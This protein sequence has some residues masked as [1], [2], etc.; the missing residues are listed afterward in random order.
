M[1]NLLENLPGLLKK[2][3]SQ[4]IKGKPGDWYNIAPLGK[5]LKE[6]GIEYIGKLKEVL[7]KVEGIEFYEDRTKTTPV[8]YVRLLNEICTIRE[9]KDERKSRPRNSARKALFEW[10]FWGKYGDTLA[11]L[12]EKSLGGESWSFENE[13]DGRFSILDSYLRYTFFRIQKEGKICYTKD[14]QWAIFNTGLVNKTYLPIYALFAKNKIQGKQSWFFNGFFAEGEKSKIGRIS[15]VDFP[16]RPRRAQYFDDPTDLLYIVSES[17][18]ELSP[19]YEHIITDNVERLPITLLREF[20]SET[21]EEKKQLKDFNNEEEYCSYCKEYKSYL[22]DMIAQGN[23]TR[24][25]QE[26]FRTAID[27]TRNRVLWNYKTAIPTY[28]PKS[29]RI[30]LLL[31]LCLVNEDKV[32]LALVVSKGDGG[33]LAETIYPLDWAYKCARLICRPDS[34]WLTPNAIT[35]SNIEEDN[36]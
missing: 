32:D 35:S 23:V 10:A 14:G 11:Q 22:Q 18:N 7:S 2:L 27:L 17:G 20:I 1:M 19:N 8:T 29:D 36:D 9:S 28:Y 6:N 12:K 30:T 5:M 21:I 3:S 34:D 16:N 26:R 13:A 15:V 33:Y 25:L 4:Q 24:K 31:P